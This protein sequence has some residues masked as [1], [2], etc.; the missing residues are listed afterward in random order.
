MI[1]K[2]TCEIKVTIL[3]SN[4][5]MVLGF[6]NFVSQKFDIPKSIIFKD[7]FYNSL[8]V[9]NVSDDSATISYMFSTDYLATKFYL[10]K[11]EPVEIVDYIDVVNPKIDNARVKIIIE[12]VS[13]K[14]GGSN[15]N[16]RKRDFS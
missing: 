6:F 3:L 11:D 1:D 16:E 10:T 5:T 8:A 4:G 2:K 13:L 7:E 15:S 12:L 14:I 9:L